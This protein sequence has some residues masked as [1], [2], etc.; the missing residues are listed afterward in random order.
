[1]RI[2][3][4]VMEIMGQQEQR[5]VGRPTK[6]DR[7]QRINVT[8]SPET[9]DVLELRIPFKQRSAY[10]ERLIRQDLGLSVLEGRV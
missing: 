10:I 5:D 3:K 8:L 7:R 9:L 6:P 2:H 1:M 4:G